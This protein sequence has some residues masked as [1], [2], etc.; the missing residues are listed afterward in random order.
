MLPPKDQITICF[1]HVAYQLQARFELRAAGIASYQ[2]WSRDELDYGITALA[3]PIKD[4]AGR[5]MAALNS[6]GYSGRLDAATMVGERLEGLQESAA[7]IS[8]A[9]RRHPALAASIGR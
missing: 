9:I 5:V 1:A 4:P 8:Q 6:S 3:V 2:V 7:A